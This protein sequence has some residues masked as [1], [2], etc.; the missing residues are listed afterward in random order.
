MTAEYFDNWYADIASSQPRQEIF[1]EHLGLPPEVG[2]SNH[3]P[4]SGL[5]EIAAALALSPE[6]E[7]VDLACGRGG[8]G[9]WIARETGA[10]LIGIDFSAEAISQASERRSLFDL[11]DRATFAVGTLEDSGLPAGSADA[12]VCVDA[13]QFASD[14]AAAAQEIRRVLRPGGRVVLTT[15]EAVSPGDEQVG[16][17]IRKV[18]LARSVG[19]AGFENINVVERADWHQSAREFWESVLAIDAGSDPALISMRTEGERSLPNHDRMRRVMA[20][21]TAP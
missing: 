21:A 8:P 18:D 4:L 20:T 6:D 9:M 7:L 10:S 14:G 5:R 3:V 2:P 12:V 15:W 19:A 13:F 1:T 11:T 17:R 16:E